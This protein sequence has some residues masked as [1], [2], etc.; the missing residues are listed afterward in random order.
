MITDT[1]T[2]EER[3]AGLDSDRDTKT[4]VSTALGLFPLL[5]SERGGRFRFYPILYILAMCDDN[6][7]WV[8]NVTA[9]SFV[10]LFASFAIEFNLFREDKRGGLLID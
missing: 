1:R 4:E 10:H 9:V 7:S 3:Y 5:L 6:T 8:C 2:V